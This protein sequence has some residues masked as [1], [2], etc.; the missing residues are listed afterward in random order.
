MDSDFSVVGVLWIEHG[1]FEFV[2][3]R[4]LPARMAKA[5]YDLNGG[6]VVALDLAR[7][8]GNYPRMTQKGDSDNC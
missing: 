3:I 8:P 5:L 2:G 1:A 7:G 4:L 6:Q